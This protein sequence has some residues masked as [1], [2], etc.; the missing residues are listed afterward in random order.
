MTG[1]S[2]STAKSNRKR[3]IMLFLSD[4]KKGCSIYSAT[5]YPIHAVL[6]IDFL[7]YGSRYLY[8]T[9]RPFE[10]IPYE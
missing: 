4:E 8:F 9:R 3:E 6:G 10:A 2:P 1:R 5:K 7:V